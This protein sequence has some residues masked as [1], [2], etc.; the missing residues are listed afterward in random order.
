MAPIHEKRDY[1][2]FILERLKEN[3]YEIRTAKRFDKKYA[4]DR[5]LIFKF[6]NDTQPDQMETLKNVYKDATEETLINFFNK[7]ITKS[8]GSLIEFLKNGVDISGQHLSF[9]YAKPTTSFNEDLNKKYEQNIFSVMEEVVVSP[10]E[11]IDLVLFLNGFAIISIELKCNFSGQNYEDAIEQYRNKRDP[12]GRLFLFKAGCLINF[13][14]DLNEVYMTTKLDGKSTFFLPFNKG[15]GEG[16]NAGKGNPIYEDK[17]SV[18]YMWEDIFQKDTI[19]DLVGKF[20]FIETKEKTNSVTGKKSISESVIFPRYHQL[21]C[22]RKVLA[23][24]S[25]NKIS[26]NYLIQHS[27]GSG[28]TNSIAWISHQLAKLHVND[29]PVFDSIIVVTDRKVIDRQLQKAIR[30]LEHKSGFIAVM[31]D[32]KSSS[33]LKYTLMNNTK[34]IVTTIQKFLYILDITKKLSNKKFA[35]I[36]DE[37][38]SSTSGKDMLALKSVLTKDEEFEDVEDLITSG[39]AKKGKAS[40]VSMIA[41]TATPK[42]TTLQI[43]G[44]QNRKGQKESFHLYSMKQAIEEGFIVDVLQSFTP[45]ET[46]YKLNK[47]VKEDPKIQTASAKKQIARFIKLHETNIAQRVEI[48]IEHFRTTVLPELDGQAKAMVVTSSREE[49]VKYRNGFDEYIRRKGYTDVKALVAFSGKIEVEIKK[50]IKKEFSEY[51]MNGFPEEKLAD[52]FDTELYNVLIVANKYQTGFDQR[53]LVGMYVL[54]KLRGV[55]AVQTFERLDRICPPYNKKTFI[56]DFVNSFD[57]IRTAY[58]KFYTTTLL[59]DSVTT[60]GIYDLETKIDSYAVIDPLD[61]KNAVNLLT[62]SKLTSKEQEQLSFYFNKCKKN[63][64]TRNIEDQLDFQKILKHFIRFYEFI[65]LATC[66][67]DKELHQKY[68]FIIGLESFLDIRRPGGGYDLTGKIQ[69][70][71]F[72]Q[73]K[74]ETVSGKP[75]IDPIIKLPTTTAFNILPAKLKKLSEIISEINKKS[76]TNFAED[77]IVQYILRIMEGIQKSEKLKISAENNTEKD[78]SFAF[79]DEIKT[80]MMDE[81]DNHRE[82]S[83][84]ILENEDIKKQTFG[85][86]EKQIYEQLRQK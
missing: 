74:G 64:E 9:M 73:K 49:A 45:Y 40:N 43:F 32:D 30:S 14:M 57:D 31:D 2:A 5:E 81:Y 12:K 80:V 24:V 86:F 83:K 70:T 6:L 54:K 10:E 85:I 18:Y 71:N 72:L 38:H 7:E 59:A 20:I 19:L 78:F 67:E 53:K 51:G 8:R 75:K 52:Y 33:D 34:I 11:R 17:Y 66:F 50:G 41:F 48:I 79:F 69:A 29:E 77:K 47:E 44:R 58:S 63:L 65:L 23:D 26:Q 56:L 13:A 4:I 84:M 28:K 25:K 36:I 37:A 39:I 46:F 22:V 16:I 35:V 68:S 1:Q 27:T 61:I 55:N 3:G 21:D 76:G 82:F 42:N 15:R 62:K 60:S